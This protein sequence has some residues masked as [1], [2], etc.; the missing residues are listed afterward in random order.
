MMQL[1]K[2]LSGPKN[3]FII[4][5]LYTIVIT[6]FL[7]IPVSTGIST[8]LPIDKLVHIVINAALIFLWLAYFFKKGLLTEQKAIITL[9][10]LSIAYGI[11]IELCQEYFTTSRSADVF[12]V[13]ANIVGC[14]TGLFIFKYL[15][16]KFSS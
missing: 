3:L 11:I 10:F 6:I 9:L 13:V 8:N 12:D 15:K 14:L 1:I 16:F 2:N 5:V 7:L 4:C